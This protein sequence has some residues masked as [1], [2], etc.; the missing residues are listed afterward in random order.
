MGD[1]AGLERR[2]SLLLVLLLMLSL[3][4]TTQAQGG[5]VLIDETSFSLMDGTMVDVE[6]VGATLELSE[7]LGSSANVS[8]VLSVQTLEG[9]EVSN[10]TQALPE[11][12]SGELRNVSITFTGLPYGHS[13]LTASLTGE[14]GATNGPL[15][16][17][18]SASVQRLRP[19][20]ITLGGPGSVVPEGVDA[21][22][23]STGNLTLHDG[24]HLA[25]EFPIINNGDVNWTGGAAVEI[26]S[27]AFHE[28]VSWPT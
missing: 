24:D 20:A 4:S 5:A 21:T 27:G 10:Q 1:G 26:R 14:V 15:V 19:L 28:T 2:R 7:V 9:E 8:I 11:F 18:V 22:G 25:L 13:V 23:Q 6:D 3:I 17:S 12:A 16:D